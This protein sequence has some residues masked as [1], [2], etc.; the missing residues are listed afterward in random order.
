M[1]SSPLDDK[2][3]ETDYYETAALY[4]SLNV[5]VDYSTLYIHII[6]PSLQNITF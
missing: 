4:G 3:K 2:K 6:F 5:L 1:W